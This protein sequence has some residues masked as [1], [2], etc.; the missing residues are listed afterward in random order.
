MIEDI[1]FNR[2]ELDVIDAAMDYFNDH[3]AFPP[4]QAPVVE[5]V[6]LKLMKRGSVSC[7]IC[8]KPLEAAQT[9]QTFHRACVDAYYTRRG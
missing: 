9:A 3:D 4:E 1:Y 6:L 7:L 2:Q 5:S 8:Q